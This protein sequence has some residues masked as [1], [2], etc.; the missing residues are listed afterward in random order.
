MAMTVT[1]GQ[2]HNTEMLLFSN[3]GDLLGSHGQFFKMSPLEESIRIP[4]L[5]HTCDLYGQQR[6]GERKR[7]LNHVDIAPTTLGLCG[8]EVPAWM[9]GADHASFL[10][11]N[12]PRRELPTSAYLQSVIPTMH[13]NSIDRPRP[14]QRPIN[15]FRSPRSEVRGRTSLYKMSLCHGVC[16]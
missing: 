7:C 16:P 15:L 14:Q 9:E 12:H 4:F 6:R 3:H 13:G 11:Q 5:Y 10:K 2:A 8:I 1:D